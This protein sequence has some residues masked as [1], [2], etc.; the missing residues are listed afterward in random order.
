MVVAAMLYGPPSGSTGES[1]PVTP[2]PTSTGTAEVPPPTVTDTAPVDL[3]S[4]CVNLLGEEY[5]WKKKPAV[6]DK[7][8]YET[9]LRWTSPYGPFELNNYGVAVMLPTGQP[10]TRLTG[11]V[12]IA[13][14]SKVSSDAQATVVV[15]I[16]GTEQ[17][18]KTITMASPLL[19]DLSVVDA[20]RVELFLTAGDE[21]QVVI[22]DLT[23]HQA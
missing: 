18:R 1:P 14:D 15:K 22:A 3:L 20:G 5:G 21:V 16:D 6:V 10:I 13:D 23:G 2:S 12:G 19:L 4:C 7:K 11:L 9:T 8:R 17:I